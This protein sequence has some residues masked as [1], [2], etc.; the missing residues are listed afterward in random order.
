[1]DSLWNQTLNEAFI[2]PAAINIFSNNQPALSQWQLQPQ[3]QPQLYA[4]FPPGINQNEA[5][6]YT[7]RD[8]DEQRPEITR[9]YENN[10]LNGVMEY[11]REQHG[12]DAT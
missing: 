10:T 12:L 7:A 4:M 2:P 9:L 11:M 1:M 5:R 3:L 8:W 6:K